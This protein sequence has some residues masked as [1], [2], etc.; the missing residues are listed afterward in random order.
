L[1]LESIR[2][3]DGNGQDASVLAPEKGLVIELSYHTQ[4]EL[5]DVGFGVSISRMDGTLVYGTNTFIDDVDLLSPLPKRGL[6]R[7]KVLEMGL[8]DGDYLLDVAAHTKDGLAYDYHKGLHR[9]AIRSK[10]RDTGV[11]RLKHRWEVQPS[12]AKAI[13]TGTA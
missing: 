9:F 6:V 12:A 13:K 10:F 1:V 2:V 8:T 11:A 3:L 7:F 4:Q 5:A